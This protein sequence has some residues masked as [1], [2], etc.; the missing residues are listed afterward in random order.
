VFNLLVVRADWHLAYDANAWAFVPTQA[1]LDKIEKTPHGTWDRVRLHLW[2]VR[3]STLTYRQPYKDYRDGKSKYIFVS[4]PELR[5]NYINRA[6]SDRTSFK[7]YWA[8]D[9]FCDFPILEHQSHPFCVIYNALP[10]LRANADVLTKEQVT[11]LRSMEVI[12]ARWRRRSR[13]PQLPSPAA[14]GKRKQDS[15]SDED[16]TDR[17]IKRKRA[18]KGLKG[19]QQ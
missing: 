8:R 18:E 6:K 19:K 17:F 11:S 14:K 1:V 9:G 10:K 7:T 13:L 3:L 5:L 16:R 12:H 4:F 15:G 2:I